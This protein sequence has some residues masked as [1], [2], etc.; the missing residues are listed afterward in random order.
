MKTAVQLENLTL[1]YEENEKTVLTDITLSIQNEQDTLILGPSGSGKSSLVQCINGLY[2]EDLDGEMKGR[3]TIYGRSTRAF[4][5][6]ELAK[7]VGSVFQDPETQFCM[8]TVEDEIA[9]GLENLHVPAEEMEHKIDD[10][11]AQV[12]LLDK[13]TSFIHHL[14][15]GQKQ[16]LAL[17]CV[18]VMEPDIL[19]LD[20]PTANLDPQSARDFITTLTSIKKTRSLTLIVIEH[21]LEGWLELLKHVVVLH[22]DGGIL[23]QGP[24]KEV[25][26]NQARAIHNQGI[27]L[28]YAVQYS[29]DEGSPPPYPFTLE[30][31]TQRD[32]EVPSGVRHPNRRGKP[33]L[34]L[35]DVQWKAILQD[36]TFSL[37][38]EEWIAVVGANGSGKSSLSKIMAGITKP[39]KGTVTWKADDLRSQVGYV[40]QNPEHQFVTDEMFEEIAFSLR[41]RGTPELEICRQVENL[42]SLCRLDGLDKHHPYQLS[43][44]QKRRLSVATMIV[45]NQSLLLLDE[46]TFGQDAVS[47]QQLM[48]LLEKR[49]Q[50]GTT[51]FMITH[52]MELV[53]HY[54]T[55]VI[56]LEQ[57]RIAYDGLPE[58]LWKH[59]RLSDWHIEPPLPVQLDRLLIERSC[60]HVP[61]YS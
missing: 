57:G 24:L 53:H 5:P 14:S 52:D 16:K 9:F 6:G 50:Q 11:L 1:T 36:L 34:E 22:S 37:Y 19:L 61:S 45:E 42:L 40:F 29:I 47:T 32:I 30:E 28:P 41:Q 17:A 48:A 27:R 46:P 26:N 12:N 39:D 7:T 15:G 60:L 13:K 43:Q 58:H 18:L 31:L 8:L 4:K 33:L 51:L 35:S 49:F 20:E 10:V 44:G 3:V 56:V 2:P 25:L 23:T 21:R 54:A 55:R 38:E 59:N